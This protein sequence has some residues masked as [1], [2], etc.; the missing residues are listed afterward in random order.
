MT[1]E[2]ALLDVRVR[3]LHPMVKDGVT[4]EYGTVVEE[5]GEDT[6]LI[7]VR[8]DGCDE[9]FA[10]H[11][12]AFAPA[13]ETLVPLTVKTAVVGTHVRLRW[14][15]AYG[16]RG[17]ISREGVLTRG[18]GMLNMYVVA[19][20]WGLHP[21]TTCDITALDVVLGEAHWRLHRR[22]AWERL[23]ADELG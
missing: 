10:Y 1:P 20:L 5:A 6:I 16:D 22:T 11:A 13:M 23:D 18:P 14:P 4:L 7:G 2:E 15:R 17:R 19:R 21:E 9:V 3:C 8:F 12:V